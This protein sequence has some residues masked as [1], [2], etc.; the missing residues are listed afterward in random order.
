MHL[1]EMLMILSMV[2]KIMFLLIG[3]HDPMSFTTLEF[4]I[5]AKTHA[6]ER[7]VQSMGKIA[8]T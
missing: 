1:G 3:L 4:Q 6:D 8:K 5:K 2:V 7:V